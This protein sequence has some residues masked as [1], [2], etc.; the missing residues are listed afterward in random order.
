MTYLFYLTSL[1]TIKPPGKR[2]GGSLNHITKTPYHPIHSFREVDFG[3][4]NEEVKA[5]LAL[6]ELKVSR[7]FD[8][9][10]LLL[11][12]DGIY[13]PPKKSL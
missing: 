5:V 12:L 4:S 7:D 10:K 9:R 1:T 2:L 6:N 8:S 11:K 13:S 3:L